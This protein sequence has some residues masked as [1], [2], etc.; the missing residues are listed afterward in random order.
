MQP[1]I[2]PL[3]IYNKTDESDCTLVTANHVL[4]RRP[5][6]EQEGIVSLTHSLAVHL[7]THPQ[8]ASALYGKPPELDAANH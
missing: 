8:T 2:A 6:N 5:A 3:D 7:L 1:C 4:L